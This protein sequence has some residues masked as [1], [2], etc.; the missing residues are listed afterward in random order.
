M[1]SSFHHLHH[2][3]HWAVLVSALILWMLG[4]AWYSPILF[5]K[6]WM[7][8]LKIVPSHSKKG[9]ARGMISSLIGDLVVAFVLI[10][11]ILWSGAATYGTGA[12]IGFLCWSWI[13]RRDTVS[14][15]HLRESSHR[16]FAINGGYGL[17]GLLITGGLLAVWK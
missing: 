8:S 3:N 13:L 15:R 12:F 17:V 4:A 14:P 5:A 2:F 6:P 16:L 10:H 11:F 9:L 1:D 7:A